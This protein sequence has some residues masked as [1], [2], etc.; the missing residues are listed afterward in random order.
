MTRNL[1]LCALTLFCFALPGAN[2]QTSGYKVGDTVTDFKL[3]NVNG[4][5]VSMKDNKNAKGYI[6]TFTCNECPYS[7]LYEDRLIA[8][9]NKY[10]P[11]GY[12]VIA[13]NPNDPVAS[14]A[15]SYELMQQRA[16]DKQFPFPYLV[17]DGQ[18]ITRAYGA[19]RTPHMYIV[20]KTGSKYTLHYIGAVDDNSRNEN[21][22]KKLYVEDAMTEI[23]AGKPVTTN[24]TKAIGC[25][26]KWRDS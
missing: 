6:I 22:V 20:G 18:K 17:D 14:P 4:Q 7:K 26:I 8:L 2:M 21:D 12:P 5:F 10:A 16:R 1:L 23:L 13:I 15:D 11:L 24:N 25:T 9:H 3:K 19:T